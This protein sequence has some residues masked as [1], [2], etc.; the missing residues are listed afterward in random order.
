MDNKTIREDIK[1]V[2]RLVRTLYRIRN[3]QLRHRTGSPPLMTFLAPQ[4]PQ[5]YST[6]RDNEIG[7]VDD[8]ST[9]AILGVVALFMMD[10]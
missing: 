3:P 4:S 6:P 1:N 9:P 7:I 2:H 10:R 5:R 8:V